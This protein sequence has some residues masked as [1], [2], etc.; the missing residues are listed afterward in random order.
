MA[1]RSTKES[2]PPDTASIT[3]WPGLS[4]SQCRIVSC[5][6]W[7]T[8]NRSLSHLTAR[9]HLRVRSEVEVGDPRP[10]IYGEVHSRGGFRHLPKNK[11]RFVSAGGLRPGT[12]DME[13]NDFQ[14]YQAA[15]V[16]M[17]TGET[18]FLG[19]LVL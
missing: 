12:L 17:T 2:L 10:R 3:V 19:L 1:S 15:P 11:L 16:H 4:M 14:R 8:L 6:R 5:R 13:W 9:S 18:R 7:M